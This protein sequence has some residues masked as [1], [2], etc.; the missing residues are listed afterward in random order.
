MAETSQKYV[1]HT[2]KPEW[3][4]GVLVSQGNGQR[5]YVF[6]DGQRRAIKEEFCARLIEEVPEPESEEDRVRLERGRNAGGVATP[7]AVHLELEAAIRN[8]PDDPGAYLVYGDWLQARGD[9]RGELIALQHQR[10]LA[11][12][13]RKLLRAEAECFKKHGGYLMPPLLGEMLQ[14]PRRKGGVPGSRCEA[15][16]HWGFLEQVRLARSSPQQPEIE[17]IAPQLLT[18]PSAQFLRCFR[19][20]PLGKLDRFDYRPIIAQLAKT[21][22]AHLEEVVLADLDPAYFD[23]AYSQ[24]GDVCALFGLPALK[25]LT[26][27]GTLHL[28]AA[29]EHSSLR[30]LRIVGWDVS[31]RTLGRLLKAR[32]PC[33]ERLEVS[34]PALSP[35][36]R[37]LAAFAKA[38]TLT[39]LRELALR[40]TT[41]T[42]EVL[43]TL[44]RSTWMKQLESLDMR[45][46]DLSDGD[47]ES[48]L[49][50]AKYLKHLKVL[51]LSG[52]RFGPEA[53]ER[54]RGLCGEVRT[55][56]PA[57][58][59]GVTA[60]RVV[61]AAPDQRALVAARALAKPEAWLTLAQDG[62]SV[63]G[64]YRGSDEYEVY[65]E[66]QTLTSG[67]TCP[68]PKAPCKHALA[69]MLIAAA[70]HDFAVV[71]MPAGLMDRTERE[72]RY[73]RYDSAWE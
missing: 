2:L 28:G 8:N 58:L 51:D 19:V 27:C 64:E 6:A 61:R 59:N 73:G 41:N 71:P 50:H 60:E 56:A 57:S 9:P 30:E 48:L 62:G 33:L 31:S 37:E 66:L 53:A 4:V 70:Q 47:V 65:V 17:E 45:E 25:R 11:P 63:W 13:D 46:R 38:E 15:N 10:S 67:C 32:L 72:V 44:A 54:L 29:V 23:I 22:P 40:Q 21:A 43:A 14:L 5:T 69:L 26:L 55:T 20:G 1:R 35:P 39:R 36:K 7:R 34:S 52:N 49:S 42:A 3:G 24:L 16:W 68:S 18:H 12:D